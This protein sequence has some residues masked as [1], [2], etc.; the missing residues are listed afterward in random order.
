[1]NAPLAAETAMLAMSTVRRAVLYRPSPEEVR[2][3]RR[4][5]ALLRA[6]VARAKF[7]EMRRL[8]AERGWTACQRIWPD[9][10]GELGPDG[11]YTGDEVLAM[12]RERFAEAIAEMNS[13]RKGA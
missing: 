12:A 3:G 10:D 6:T 4:R 8:L 7:H 9:I 2:Q 11:A 5:N 1:M 13:Y